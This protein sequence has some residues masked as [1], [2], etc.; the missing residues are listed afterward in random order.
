MNLLICV[1]AKLI[2]D[3]II[4]P[5][6]NRNRNTKPGWNIRME[7]PIKRRHSEDKSFRD[8]AERKDP[9]KITTDQFDNTAGRN[10]SKDISENRKTGNVSRLG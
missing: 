7:K 3:D 2:N 10:K 1:G 6:R 9:Q 4:I 5:V 8:P